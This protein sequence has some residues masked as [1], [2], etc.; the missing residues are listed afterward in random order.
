VLIYDRSEDYDP[1]EESDSQGGGRRRKTRG[2][3]E[4]S[5]GTIIFCCP[6]AGYY[7]YMYCDVRKLWV[8]NTKFQIRVNGLSYIWEMDLMYYCGTIEDM[9]E[10]Q[11]HQ[12]LMFI[13][14]L[15]AN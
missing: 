9:E 8:R 14:I 5:E 2:E 7:E 12:T 13:L 6:N 1:D 4:L 15:F 11:E 3:D 10:A